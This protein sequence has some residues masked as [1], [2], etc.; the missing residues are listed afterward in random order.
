MIDY[1]WR[2]FGQKP[3]K[4]SPYLSI[5]CT[6]LYNGQGKFHSSLRKSS[7]LSSDSIA[8]ALYVL[9]GDGVYF[10]LT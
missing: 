9:N 3:I 2:K 10:Y 5:G 7:S 6:V 1:S 8:N 4:G